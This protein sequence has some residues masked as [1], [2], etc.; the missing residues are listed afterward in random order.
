MIET[1]NQNGTPTLIPDTADYFIYNAVIPL[2]NSTPSRAENEPDSILVREGIIRWI[3]KAGETGAPIDAYG[4]GAFPA[5]DAGGKT[6]IPGFIDNH[7]H[8]LIAGELVSEPDLTGLNEEE[9]REK[10]R[11]MKANSS[12]GEPLYAHGW[13]YPNWPEPHRSLIDQLIP[14]RPVALF[15]FSGHGACVNSA[16]LDTLGIDRHTP[17]PDGGVIVRDENGEPTGILREAASSRIHAARMH[18]INRDRARLDKCLMRAQERFLE[19]GITSVGDNTWYPPSARALARLRRE[20]RLRFRVSTWSL[21]NDRKSRLGMNFVRYDRHYVRRGAEKYFLDGAFSTHTAL[22][23]EPYYGEK[24]NWGTTV[25]GPPRLDKVLRSLNRRRQQGAFHAIGDRA[26]RNF[27][28]AVARLPSTQRRRVRKMRHRLEHCQLVDPSDISRFRDFGVLVAA[29]PHAISS[30]EKDR[31]L[32]GPERAQKAYPYRSLLDA[33]V[34]LSFGS[35]APAEPSFAPLDGIRKA[36]LR[37]N[38]ERIS[39]REAVLCYTRE[40]AYAEGTEDWKGSLQEGMV[41]DFTILSRN[42]LEYDMS[43]DR[44]VLDEVAVAHTVVGGSFVYTADAGV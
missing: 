36:C 33:G 1:R 2:V 19:N 17:D 42:P 30:P 37:E 44:S 28:D 14:D 16:M 38:G 41:A 23:L 18:M 39:A 22:L 25:L 15:Q 9:I 10:L 4:R 11:E 13:D 20:G 31:S 21:G 40:C 34:H 12:P 8:T 29:Q 26:V 7:V 3:G 27:L 43:G 6:V 24:D 5:W 32:L 35:D